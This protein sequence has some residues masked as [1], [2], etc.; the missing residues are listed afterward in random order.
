MTVNTTVSRRRTSRAMIA[1]GQAVLFPEFAPQPRDATSSTFSDNMQLPVHRWFRFSAGFS[2]AWAE[3][4]IREATLRSATRVLDPFAGSG[5]TLICAETV[6]VASYGIEAHPF[7]ER[8]SR[9]KLG[10]HSAPAAFLALVQ[11]I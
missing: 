6:G 8:I 10:R 7:L 2:A 9:A 4:M 3:S 1:R 5:T 11:R